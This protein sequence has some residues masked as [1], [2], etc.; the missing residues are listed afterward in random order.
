MHISNSIQEV[1]KDTHNLLKI[2]NYGKEPQN[3]SRIKGEL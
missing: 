1:Q 3:L 2:T